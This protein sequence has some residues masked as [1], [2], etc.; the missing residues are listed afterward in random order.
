[1]APNAFGQVLQEQLFQEPSVRSP[2]TNQQLN[3]IFLCAIPF[4]ESL[5]GVRSIPFISTYP[6]NSCESTSAMLAAI[7]QKLDHQ[8]DVLVVKGTQA[9]GYGMHFWVEANGCVLDPTAHQFPE[10]NAPIFAMHPSPLEKVFSHTE[11]FTPEQALTQCD[12]KMGF[13]RDLVN[14]LVSKFL[15][16]AYP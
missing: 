9:S 4:F 8:L 11:L 15:T 6:V 14:R 10:Y 5:K 1:M 16:H 3:E 12:E 2:M 7:L 13:P